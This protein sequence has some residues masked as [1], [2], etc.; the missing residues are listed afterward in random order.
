MLLKLPG[1]QGPPKTFTAFHRVLRFYRAPPAKRTVLQSPL[2]K[3]SGFI[4]PLRKNGR[5]YRGP[6]VK[7][8]VL[9]S[10]LGKTSGFTEPLR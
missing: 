2:G 10:P 4:E 6:S 7:Q 3:T 8:A 1:P 9:P 5:F